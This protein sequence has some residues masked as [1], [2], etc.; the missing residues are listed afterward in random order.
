VTVERAESALVG[1]EPSPELFDRVAAIAG[2]DCDPVADQRG[3]VE[4]K[5]HLAAELT[6]RALH[7]AAAR[8]VGE[9]A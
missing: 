9:E 5:R 8:A 2:E 3:S 7:R 4:Y 6:R 1:R